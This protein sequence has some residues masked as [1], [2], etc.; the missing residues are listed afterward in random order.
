MDNYKV[1]AERVRELD[2]PMREN[3]ESVAELSDNAWTPRFEGDRFPTMTQV[4]Q[5]YQSGYISET[6][7]P[8][9][10]R[11]SHAEDRINKSEKNRDACKKFRRLLRE[12]R[13]K[14]VQDMMTLS[15]EVC[16][17]QSLFRLM[18]AF[19]SVL[20]LTDS[21]PYPFILAS[22]LSGALTLEPTSAIFDRSSGHS[23]QSGYRDATR[24]KGRSRAAEHHVPFAGFFLL[25][26]LT[27]C[28]RKANSPTAAPD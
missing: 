12:R 22:V 11:D 2:N 19:L 23:I 21:I 20:R 26:K 3:T 14:L 10:A 15:C 7:G 6:S 17:D 9:A 25:L 4:E 16:P 1:Q 24:D 8:R 28:N 5:M 18:T 13:K 27:M